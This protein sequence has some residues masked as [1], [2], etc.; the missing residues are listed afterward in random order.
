MELKQKGNAKLADM[1]VL[2][3]FLED[4]PYQSEVLN[5]G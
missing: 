4:L 2:G 3:E 5:P 1:G